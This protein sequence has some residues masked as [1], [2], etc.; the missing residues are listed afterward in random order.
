MS[1]AYIIKDT[2]KEPGI[3]SQ[4]LATEASEQGSR[5]KIIVNVSV[6]SFFQASGT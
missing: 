1:Q 4:I 6:F 2:V 3:C 5:D